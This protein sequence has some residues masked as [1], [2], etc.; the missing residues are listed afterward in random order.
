MN[1]QLI[2]LAKTPVAGRVKTR[3]CPPWTPQEAAR[4]AAAALADTMDVVSATPV[5][6]RTLV[7]E[8]DLAAPEGW[9]RRSQRGS[10]LGERIA[11]AFADTAEPGLVTLLIG[12]DTPQVTPKILDQAVFRLTTDPGGAVIGLAQDGGWW[13]LGL[14][15]ASAAQALRDV[16]TS[17][18]ETGAMTL[19]ALRDQGLQPSVLP[20]LQDVDTAADARSVAALCRPDSRFAR[21]VAG[22]A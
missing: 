1:A 13:I 3:L 19:L 10:G 21:T 2:L 11:H 20:T 8:G 7:V 18:G 9:S 12:M 16:P 15:D 17:T 14:R 4:L 5:A 6:R 22:L